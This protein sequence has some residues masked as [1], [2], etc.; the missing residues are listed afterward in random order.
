MPDRL[1]LY[2]DLQRPFPELASVFITYPVQVEMWCIDFWLLR[3]PSMTAKQWCLSNYRAARRVIHHGIGIVSS[4]ELGTW[5][6]RHGS[7]N[8]SFLPTYIAPPDIE[9]EPVD[10]RYRAVVYPLRFADFDDLIMANGVGTSSL[11]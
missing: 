10:E 1:A 7:P 4:R 8:P 2:A 11:R 5:V 3:T 9:Y 6:F